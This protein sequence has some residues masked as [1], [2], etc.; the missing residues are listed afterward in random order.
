MKLVS[1]EYSFD[2]ILYKEPRDVVEKLGNDV[3]H[4][5]DFLEKEEFYTKRH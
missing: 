5:L 4:M 2:D 1:H 3:L